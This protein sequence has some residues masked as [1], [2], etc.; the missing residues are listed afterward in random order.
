METIEIPAGSGDK[1][2]GLATT[3]PTAT[4]TEQA[5]SGTGT[6][7]STVCQRVWIGVIIAV[8]V[9]VA[10][11]GIVV[12]VVPEKNKRKPNSSFNSF[13]DDGT[14]PITGAPFEVEDTIFSTNSTEP[15]ASIE[16]VQ[17][18]IEELTKRFVNGIILSEGNPGSGSYFDDYHDSSWMMRDNIMFA[19]GDM[20]MAPSASSASSTASAFE[21][22]TDFDTYQQEVGA[23]RNDLVKSNGD[24]VFAVS[25]SR[26]MVWDI[27]G[28]QKETIIFEPEESEN[29]EWNGFRPQVEALLLNPEGTKLIVVTTAKGYDYWEYSYETK[30]E[31]PVIDNYQA[32]QIVVYGIE[33]GSLTELSKS[34]LNGWHVDSY[35]V[36]NNVHI[37]T[38]MR[39]KI[40]DMLTE[41][42]R[43][44]NIDPSYEMT[45]EQYVAAASRKAEE[46][47]PKFVDKMVDFVTEDEEIILCRF[48]GFPDIMERYNVLTQISSFDIGVIDQENGIELATSKSLVLRPGNNGYVYATDAWIWVSDST[49]IYDADRDE[50]VDQTMLQGFRLD[51]ASST[52][53]AVGNIPGSLLNQFAID[54]VKDSENNK[55][56][57]RV[58]TTQSI[59]APFWGMPRPMPMIMEDP[60]EFDDVLEDDFGDEPESRTI[61][62]IM[63][64]EVP[65]VEDDEVVDVVEVGSVMVGKKDETITAIRFFDNISYV[66]TFERTD[67]FYVLDL[68]EPTNPK[69][70]GELEI[71]GFSEFMHPIKEDNSMLITVGKDADEDGRVVGLM[72]SLFNSTIPTE[73]DLVDK[74]VIES[75]RDSWSGSTASW[76]ERAFR[77]IQVGELGRLIIPVDIYF[78]GW[79][80]FG[81]KLGDDFAGFMVFGVDLTQSENLITLEHEIN[82]VEQESISFEDYCYC[83]DYYYTSLPQR[84]MM[85]D[86]D[87]MTL[88]NDQVISTDIVT[89]KT[90]WNV[91]YPSYRDNSCCNEDV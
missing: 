53:G 62:K 57:I 79:D 4:E 78:Y 71:P 48:V 10:I 23:I 42:L 33:G 29:D 40:H 17:S 14:P 47:M 52:F 18:D 31:F 35:I 75:N 66:V 8:V 6:K 26:I 74:L 90:E 84:S 43:R 45:D 59:M 19:E 72:I 73:P 2:E 11:V 24:H 85:F 25:D 49:Y 27:K 28:N 64:L 30:W 39:L 81:N 82:H 34:T 70:L 5:P 13:K 37:V 56:Y 58:G 7:K 36:G 46:I 54:F 76:D 67:P 69:I 3:M 86:G 77:Y 38:K 16:E 15:Y 21:G 1:G 68:S 50:H 44:W 32:T 89:G 22:T 61:N 91:T 55:E 20:A 87:I 60:L 88:K 41:P 51:G 83:G 63:I 9:I 12:A 65:E 80:K